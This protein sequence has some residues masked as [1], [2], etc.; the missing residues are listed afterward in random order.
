MLVEISM[1][2]VV[3]VRDTADDRIIEAEELE[4]TSTTNLR[5]WMPVNTLTLRVTVVG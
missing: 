5:V 3:A 4:F 1:D 2:A